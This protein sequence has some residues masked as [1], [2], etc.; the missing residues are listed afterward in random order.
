MHRISRVGTRIFR[1]RKIPT[2]VRSARLSCQ[3]GDRAS[4]SEKKL[5]LH[6]SQLNDVVVLQLMR[7]RAQ[8]F[9]VNNGEIGTL[10]M[11]NEKTLRSFC[12]NG[13][14]NSRLAD[15]GE[16]LAERQLS[17]G[18]RAGKYLYCAVGP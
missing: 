8:R 15:S 10:D 2:C 13:D 6:A 17:A 4:G 14:L 18:I 11:R 1:G 3:S 7:L 5:H 12:D 9:T 16:R